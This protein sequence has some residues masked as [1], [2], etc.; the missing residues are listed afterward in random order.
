VFEINFQCD[1]K[2]EAVHKVFEKRDRVDSI[3]SE[4]FFPTKGC[5]DV[6]A[7]EQRSGLFLRSIVMLDIIGQRSETLRAYQHA[8]GST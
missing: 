3:S 4:P 6:G 2:P 1:C 7:M 8:E 5:L